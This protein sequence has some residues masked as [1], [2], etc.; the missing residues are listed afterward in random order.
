[1][2]DP[3]ERG[4]EALERI[5]VPVEWEHVLDHIEHGTDTHRQDHP[6]PPRKVWWLVAAAVL[7]L[8]GTAGVLIVAP[9][10]PLANL[11]R[12]V[13]GNSQDEGSA[14]AP[15][16]AETV[17]M[18]CA[19]APTP[20]VPFVPASDLPAPVSSEDADRAMHL[21]LQSDVFGPCLRS[22]TAELTDMVLWES[23]SGKGSVGVVA[24]V[25]FTQPVDLPATVRGWK[26]VGESE[27]LPEDDLGRM[28]TTEVPRA[29]R[30][31][32]SVE[33]VYVSFVGEPG[34]H[35]GTKLA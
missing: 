8:A 30:S 31:K 2:S 4:V 32:V 35:A 5:P 10:R 1:M 21:L 16:P 12:Y 24:T 19:D 34:V 20:P 17:V 26:P 6:R 22:H 25:A 3:V 33:L 18:P 9:P 13:T 27:A 29:A 23:A 7:I 28:I 11:Y 14:K 15:D